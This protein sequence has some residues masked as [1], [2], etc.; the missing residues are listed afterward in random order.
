MPAVI[1]KETF[2]FLEGLTRHND[3]EWFAANKG[4]YLLSYDNFALFVQQLLHE[5]SRFDDSVAGLDA[6]DAVFRI[7]RDIRFSKDKSPYKT[8]FAAALSGR[9]NESASAG[10]YV[11][12]AP[13]KS[14]LAGGVHMP[15]PRELAKI[16]EA[17]SLRGKEFLKIISGRKFRECFVLEG[18]KLVRVPQGFD[19]QDP[20][21]EYLKY[22]DLTIIHPLSDKDVFSGTFVPLCAGIIKAMV[23]FNAFL[24]SASG[25]VGK[26]A[27]ASERTVKAALFGKNPFAPWAHQK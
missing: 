17:I 12:L 5:V 19:K 27:S 1:K 22:K 8:H 7:Y 10:Y 15:E 14:F 6:A 21:A 9:K 18:E 3:R 23:P 16:R 24:N 25:T 20:M 13:G 26:K 11:L 4:R 2:R